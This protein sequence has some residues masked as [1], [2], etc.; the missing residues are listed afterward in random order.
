MWDVS[1]ILSLEVTV[2]LSA[3]FKSSQWGWGKFPGLLNQQTLGDTWHGP[4]KLS[5]KGKISIWI[6]DLEKKE[7]NR[8]CENME[9]EFLFSSNPRREKKR[10]MGQEK[11]EEE[12]EEGIELSVH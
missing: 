10:G 6:P 7:R 1:I 5:P 11:E 8:S 4:A 3:I 2:I 9:N 12:E